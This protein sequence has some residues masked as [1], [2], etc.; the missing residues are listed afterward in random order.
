VHKARA[1]SPRFR[2]WTAGFLILA[3]TL[4]LVS[5]GWEQTCWGVLHPLPSDWSA[6]SDRTYSGVLSEANQSVVVPLPE[7]RSWA[8]LTLNDFWT[9]DTPVTLL[10][11]IW[12]DSVVLQLTNCTSGEGS[13]IIRLDLLGSLTPYDH[14]GIPTLTIARETGDAWFTIRVIIEVLAPVIPVLA[15]WYSFLIGYVVALSLICTGFTI[16]EDVLRD[17]RRGRV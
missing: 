7:L 11:R 10:L 12:N 6:I 17:I 1:T 8:L 3:G 9:N 13:H 14:A 4:I 16:I 15:P 2:L 5:T